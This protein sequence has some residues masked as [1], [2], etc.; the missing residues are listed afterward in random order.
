[1]DELR[2]PLAQSGPKPNNMELALTVN[3]EPTISHVGTF[4]NQ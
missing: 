3:H 4:F 2:T 1:M